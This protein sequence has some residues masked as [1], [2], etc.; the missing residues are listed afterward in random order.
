[1]RRRNTIKRLLAL[2]ILAVSATLVVLVLVR[3]RE[4]SAPGDTL[5][6]APANVDVSME[7]LHLNEV[8]DGIKKW[9]LIAERAEYDKKRDVTLLRTVKMVMFGEKEIKDLTITA[10]R[11]E[12]DNKSRDV[13][14]T[15]H[16][17]AVTSGGMTF[18][19][20]RARY[21]AAT[22]RI[23]TD[24]RVKL[25]HQRLTVEGVGM[26]LMLKEKSAKVLDQVSATV[27]PGE[28]R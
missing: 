7:G 28:N 15:G 3:V 16:V 4:D 11:A 24:D 9:D 6:P 19:T 1:M 18:T 22:S 8:K 25:V 26:E 23:T 5:P 10:D 12:Y 14:M 2:A 21:D 17:K 20:G 13:K 27:N